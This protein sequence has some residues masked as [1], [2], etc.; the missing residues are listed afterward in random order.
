MRI[1]KRLA[2]YL[3]AAGVIA[4]ATSMPALADDSTFVE[5]DA[6][7]AGAQ[8]PGWK[9]GDCGSNPTGAYAWHFVLN[10]LDKDTPAGDLDAAFESAGT[11]GAGGDAKGNGKTQHFYVYTNGP[12]TLLAATA[13]VVAQSSGEPKLILSHVAQGCVDETAGSTEDATTEE[14]TVEEETVEE[15]STEDETV[16]D[17]TVEEETV[18]DP[19]ED[20]SV[21]DEAAADVPASDGQS[22][23]F[24][25]LSG[26]SE[27]GDGTQASKVKPASHR[28]NGAGAAVARTQLAKTGTPE[29]AAWLGLIFLTAGI[30]LRN[31]RPSRV[32][33]ALR[34]EQVL[35][36]LAAVA[37]Y[38]VREF[39]LRSSDVRLRMK[40]RQRE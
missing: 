23:D 33:T 29:T 37:A 26:T 32:A 17:G 6:S 28:R 31:A 14:E 7:H 40:S 9:T 38:N 27:R 34:R 36:P 25:V 15:G 39:T 4:A 2:I 8:N 21:E 22:S 11:L 3:A 20:V 18:E 24:E 1:S 30:L 16:I 10:G 13:T 12:D 5:L 35:D 19:A